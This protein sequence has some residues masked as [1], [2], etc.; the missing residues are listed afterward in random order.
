MSETKADKAI[1]RVAREKKRL[2]EK[3]NK[4]HWKDVII[5]TK[6]KTCSKCKET[7]PAEEF[8][9]DQKSKDNLAS[10]CKVCKNTRNRRSKIQKSGGINNDYYDKKKI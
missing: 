5:T 3:M 6:N 1:A 8:G 9:I 7:K 10:R 4:V 2:L